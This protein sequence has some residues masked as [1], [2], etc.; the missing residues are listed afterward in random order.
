M[1]V[2]QKKILVTYGLPYANGKLHLGHALGLLQ[3]DCYVRA[4]RF[5]GED[6]LF[7][8]GDDAHGTPIMLNAK[9]QGKSSEEL[10]SEMYTS[11]VN[12]IEGFLISVNHYH[13]THCQLNTDIVH[14]VYHK[15][16]DN[17]LIETKN[18]S[19]A[20]D[21]AS[22]MFLPDRYVKGDCPLCDAKGQYGDHCEVCGKTYALSDLKNPVS[23]ISNETPVWKESEHYFYKLSKK[24]ASIEKWLSHSNVQSS[25]KNKLS[26][27]F[28]NLQ[29]WDISRDAPYFGI[30]IPNTEN[31]YFYVWLDAPFGYLT[32]MGDSQGLKDPKAVFSLWNEYKIEHFIGK[33]IVYFHGVFWPSVLESAGLNVPSRLH[34]HGFLTIMGEKMS[35]S[36]G[37]F[38]LLEDYLDKLPPDMLRYYF[39]SR[40]SSQVSDV[41]LNWGDFM[42]K[43]NS[44]LVGKL[45]NIGN[46][47]QNFLH[48]HYHGQLG[49]NVDI[50]LWDKLVASQ[51]KIEQAYRDVDLSGVCRIVM[52]LCDYTNQYIDHHKPWQIAKTEQKK[53]LL[54]ICTT[55][56]N[57]FRFLTYRLAP[58]VPTIAKAVGKSFDEE[59][60]WGVEPLLNQACKPFPHLLARITEDQI[61]FS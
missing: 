25:I 47:T 50:E 48:K 58:M 5:L 22:S 11:H 49:S 27:W 31:K 40:L 14:A 7:V 57:A 30:Q 2:S 3:T 39:A 45:I 1:V 56:L 12:D 29:D 34:V 37:T 6:V 26:E 42:Q 33:D 36:R 20:Y 23:V 16:E 15:L 8:C 46:R 32:V 52:E 41:D 19:Q 61:D 17:H 24:Q 44:D 28:G 60:V 13:T 9:K 53:D 18:I 51:D 4:L 55:A 38:V 43:V 54:I 10:I 59:I 35:K 21:E